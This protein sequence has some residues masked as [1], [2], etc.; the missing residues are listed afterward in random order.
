MKYCIES[1]GK[2]KRHKYHFLT[3]IKKRRANWF[4]HTLSMNC[5]LHYVVEGK[6]EGRIEV[7]GG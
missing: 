4:V 5:V 3:T 2:V 6:T 1:S 7:A